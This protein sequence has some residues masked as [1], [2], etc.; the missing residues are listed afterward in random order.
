MSLI[1]SSG[2][3]FEGL[4]VPLWS[5][6]C[7]YARKLTRN[8]AALAEDVV[9][10]AMI[11]AMAAWERWSPEDMEPALA[12]RAW[13]YRVVSNVAINTFRRQK[14][15][16]HS[17]L[18]RLPEIVVEL[19]GD[20]DVTFARERPGIRND[21]H[22][23]A[24]DYGGG[25]AP[26]AWVGTA[27]EADADRPAVSEE[28]ADAVARLHPDRRAVIERYYFLGQTCEQIALELD[29]PADTVR[30]RLVRAREK[31]APLLSRFARL[32]GL[33]ARVHAAPEPSKAVQPD[34]DAVNG[35]M[36]RH[37]RGALGRLEV[38]PDQLAA[39]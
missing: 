36:G 18:A 5:E 4:C 31:L 2:Y 25:M 22:A 21:R 15:E 13:M 26:V 39:S 16:T 29:M 10:D 20:P 38:A 35:I 19:H 3:S 8:N 17:R 28:V 9:Q 1:S 37:D 7:N 34:P 30:T 14:L 6:M 24:A 32:N 27:F 11:K 12:A 33:A 23:E